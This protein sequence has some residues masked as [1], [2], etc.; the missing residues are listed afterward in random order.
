MPAPHPKRAGRL[1]S[2][3]SPA[4]RCPSSAGTG[5]RQRPA[6]QHPVLPEAPEHAGSVD[7]EELGVLPPPPVSL[8]GENRGGRTRDPIILPLP[9]PL[10]LEGLADSALED[11]ESLRQ[12]MLWRLLPGHA[13]EPQAAGAPEDDLTPTAPASVA[14]HPWDAGSPGRAPA[15][16]EGA[17][18]QLP[19]PEGAQAKQGA[20]AICSL[21]HLPPRTRH[22]GVWEPPELDSTPEEEASGPEAARSYQVV[23]KG[24]TNGGP[25][26]ASDAA[27]PGW[28]W[29]FCTPLPPPHPGATLRAAR[30]GQ[31]GLWVAPRGWGPDSR[32]ARPGTVTSCPCDFSTNPESSL[33]L[34]L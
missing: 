2:R 27:F 31:G 33:N 1:E 6:G 16:G 28:G 18:T 3:A 15:G 11:V 12:L 14:S 9:G 4:S 5:P 29:V 10:L 23:R 26:W 32:G 34:I 13:T 30:P 21:E 19:G 17:S 22:S 8:D 20:A 7:E 24:K 25:P